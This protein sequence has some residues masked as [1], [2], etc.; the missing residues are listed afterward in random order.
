[1]LKKAFSVAFILLV[2]AILLADFDYSA[3]SA[4]KASL[5]PPDAS[6]VILRIQNRY[7]AVQCDTDDGQFNIGTSDDV[8][9]LY[10]FP[11]APW[12]SHTIVMIDG[13]QYCNND[14]VTSPTVLLL[15]VTDPFRIIPVSGDTSMIYGGWTAMGVDIKQTLMPVYLIYPSDTTGTILIRYDITNR[16]TVPHNVGVMLEMDTMVGPNDAAPL[17]TAFGYSAIERDFFA[18][19]SMPA[20]WFA[21]EIGP[22]V[23]AS[24]Q[25]VAFGII[26]GY[27]A[28]PPDRFAVGA[29]YRFYRAEWSYRITSDTYGDS[30]VLYWWNPIRLGPGESRTVATYYGLGH[31]MG[32]PGLNIG[33]PP[34]LEVRRCAYYPNPFDIT[35]LVTNLGMSTLRNVQVVLRLSRGLVFNPGEDS[36]KTV[37]PSDLR[38]RESGT[39]GWSV[40]ATGEVTGVINFQVCMHAAGGESLCADA[41]IIVPVIGDRP[42]ASIL[43][44]APN[45][46]T[47]LPNQEIQVQLTTYNG[48]LDAIMHVN[49]REY[50]VVRDSTVLRYDGRNI[51]FTPSTPWHDNDTVTYELV[52]ASDT[53][54]CTLTEPVGAT[55]WV[56]LTGPVASSEFPPNGTVLGTTTLPP[57]TIRLTDSND[58]VDPRSIRFTFNGV[59]YTINSPALT[60]ADGILTFNPSVAGIVAED[61]DTFI[62]S[63]DSAT[64]T[65]P[66]YGEPNPLAHPYSWRFSV[67][68][69]DLALVDTSAFPGETLLI[70]I[71]C[72]DLSNYGIT[73]FEIR[74]SYN[75]E[76][77]RPI[78]LVNTGTATA[79][80]WRTNLTS[81]AG[82]MTITGSGSR[83]S[84]AGVLVYVRVLVLPAAP[85]GAFSRINFESLSFNGGALFAR[86]VDGIIITLWT[87]PEWLMELVLEAPSIPDSRV[88][89]T[90]GA[91][92]SGTDAFD[93]GLD[94]ISLPPTP[95]KPSFYFILNDPAHPYITG[96]SRD[97]RNN[98]T[99]PVIWQIQTRSVSDGVMR[100]DPSMLPEGNFILNGYID[101]HR[102]SVYHFGLDEVLT[103][104]YSRATPEVVRSILKRGWNLV[105]LPVRVTTRFRLNDIYPTAVGPAYWFD[106]N[107][108]VYSATNIPEPGRGYWLLLYGDDTVRYAGSVVR[109]LTIPLRRGWN[110][111]GGPFSTSPIPL[112]SLRTEPDGIILPGSFYRY[113]AVREMYA[114]AENL[115]S[116]VGYWVLAVANGFLYIDSTGL[117]KSVIS[118]EPSLV[119][120][121]YTDDGVFEFGFDSE[122]SEGMDRFDAF[123]PPAPPEGKSD[124]CGFEVEGFMASRDIRPWGESVW[125]L[126]IGSCKAV[127]WNSSVLP[128]LYEFTITDGKISVDMRENSSFVPTSTHLKLVARSAVPKALDLFAYPNPFNSSV[129]IEVEMPEKGRLDLSIYNILGEKLVSVA[130]GEYNSGRIKFIWDGRDAKG[131]ALPSG[132]YFVSLRA[133]ERLIIKRIALMK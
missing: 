44:P 95:G 74:I 57:V 122:A 124:M 27:D 32:R 8:T 15:S 71:N 120:P 126:T 58:E 105:S 20:Y 49:G 78:E 59:T 113:D 17:A 26:N 132:V 119:V 38:A 31:P 47:T 7:V 67:N 64:D 10:A 4:H 39:A 23:P 103:I 91:S 41:G 130:S 37:V 94:I 133:G 83:L 98:E 12:S 18:P 110:L 73:N 48:F 93:S 70:P 53:V 108:R 42:T 115:E 22:D 131:Q 84:S 109:S 21:Y 85:E 24:E 75:D 6:K 52:D 121:I 99:L 28:V 56:D 60:Y 63:L 86:G 36:V 96:L 45:T 114:S 46:R 40:V 55:F 80:G 82:L 125:E 61:G 3:Y 35:A 128:D 97:I 100:W 87:Y 104:E 111:I 14:A 1:M 88:R 72:E 43:H 65:R 81:S 2:P 118:R 66:D 25:H 16:D 68:I 123:I 89:L 76:V 107:A 13:V 11:S 90:F 5:A 69:L 92:S 102:D 9:L 106:P 33:V 129:S 101:M 77:I 30:A 79:S 62:A 34:R 117:A 116:G 51:I 19:D 29:W 50:S 112:S 127:E 54:G